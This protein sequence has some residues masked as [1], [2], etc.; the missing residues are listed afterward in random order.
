MGESS[1]RHRSRRRSSKRKDRRS[2]HDEPSSASA[3]YSDDRV[4]NAVDDA[5]DRKQS[6]RRRRKQREKAEKREKKERQQR[7]ESGRSGKRV[8]RERK[9]MAVQTSPQVPVLV[10]YTT[11]D[12]G[13]KIDSLVFDTYSEM[14]RYKQS[15]DIVKSKRKSRSRKPSAVVQREDDDYDRCYL[16]VRSKRGVESNLKNPG[17]FF[18]YYERP[19]EGEVPTAVQLKIAYLSADSE[20]HHYPIQCFAGRDGHSHYVVMQNES[21]GKMFT[22]ILSLVKYYSHSST[23][24]DEAAT[25]NLET[26]SVPN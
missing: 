14:M 2:T 3:P 17:Q 26:F 10:G 22:S 21:D 20:V 13:K 23:V 8:R 4:R 16:G 1:S 9:C 25:G 24:V 18:L 19:R 6:E 5:S 7:D 12:D 15:G 11:D